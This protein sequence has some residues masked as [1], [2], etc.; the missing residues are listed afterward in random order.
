M[1][2][3]E[4]KR[5]FIH[6]RWSLQTYTLLGFLFGLIIAKVV[7]GINVLFALLSIFLLWSGVTLF[8]SYYDKDDK[9]V[10]GLKNPP[11]VNKSLFYG[12]II[13]KLLALILALFINKIFLALTI[14]TIILSFLYSHRFFRFKSN[15]FVAL[16][17]NFIAGFL[18]FLSASSLSNLSLLKYNILL[19]SFSSGFFLMSIYLMMQVHQ[20]KDDKERGD[21]SYA[22]MFGRN[23][24]LITS[25]LFLILAGLFGLTSLYL[26]SLLFQL[27]ILVAYMIIGLLLVIFWIRDKNSKREFDSMSKVT[28]YFSFVGTFILLILYI[29]QSI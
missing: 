5:V 3:K 9:P 20:I 23:R 18:T 19:G 27:F 12:S 1:L 17:F 15:G 7:F 14:I 25:I 4:V 10:A 11:K 13:F 8:N 29:I 22:L 28:N 26:S 24:A 16:F 6:I 21:I 2:L